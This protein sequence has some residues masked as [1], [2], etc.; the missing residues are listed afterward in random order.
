MNSFKD[1]DSLFNPPTQ[2]AFQS[3]SIMEKL[4]KIKDNEKIFF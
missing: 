3:R 2:I 4:Y 1:D